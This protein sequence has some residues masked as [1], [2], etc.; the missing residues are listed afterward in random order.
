[1][2]VPVVGRGRR[3]TGAKQVADLFAPY[4]W[5]RTELPRHLLYSDIARS[6]A[7]QIGDVPAAGGPQQGVWPSRQRIMAC[8]RHLAM[9]SKLQGLL[10]R[11]L[12]GAILVVLGL[13]LQSFELHAE[14]L[15]RSMVQVNGQPG[16]SPVK[17]YS[18]PADITP[19]R[20]PAGGIDEVR[21]F[22]SGTITPAD[23][24][25]AAV[26]TN[27]VRSGKQKIAGNTVWLSS[28]GG[29]IDTG[30]ALGRAWRQLGVFTFIGRDDQCLSA[31]VFAYM[32]GERR[33]TAG[34]IGIHRPFFPFTQDT[35]DR[36]ARFR[37][38]QRVL[39]DYVEELD[40]PSSLY[41]A[42]MLVPPE[43]MQFLNPA[44]L[45]RFYL[46]GISPSSEDA[47]DA[48]AARRLELSMAQYLAR[49]AKV[50]D[51]VFPLG[52]CD[53]QAQETTASGGAPIEGDGQNRNAAASPARGT[54]QGTDTRRVAWRNAGD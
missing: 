6:M 42:I 8:N 23:L 21:V 34:R 2:A 22:L 40:F 7:L 35:T 48:A 15:F 10:K 32:G 26:M 9:W 19:T 12:I 44:D 46:E 29:D 5:Q 30:M 11:R 33:S 1:L 38:L 47:A 20:S 52:R 45:K 43:S 39:K 36:R 31:C 49:K 25:S 14:L 13:G 18:N 41:E 51:C 24:A 37:H 16:W 17:K 28:D 3:Q 54:T 4:V 53:N 27:L 50:I